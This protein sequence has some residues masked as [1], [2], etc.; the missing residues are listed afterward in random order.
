[1]MEPILQPLSDAL[2]KQAV[3][4]RELGFSVTA[5]AAERRVRDLRQLAS[6]TLVS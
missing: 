5:D 3:I 1:M 4:L 6:R 2:E